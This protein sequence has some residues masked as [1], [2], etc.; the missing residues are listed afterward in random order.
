MGLGD[1]IIEASEC[2]KFWRIRN[3]II[4]EEARWEQ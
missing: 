3:I 4:H 1:D 2:L